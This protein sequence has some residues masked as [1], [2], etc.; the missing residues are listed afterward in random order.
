MTATNSI[1]PPLTG[2]AR[3]W[4][5]R[6]PVACCLAVMA[7]AIITAPMD[8]YFERRFQ[9]GNLLEVLR[10]TAMLLVALLTV[11]E[12]PKTLT[13]GFSLV[14]PALVFRWACHLWPELIPDWIHLVP[15]VLFMLFVVGHLLRFVLCAARV[16]AEVLCASVVTYLLLGW[17]W[18]VGYV[19]ASEMLP[20]AFASTVGPPAYHH[21]IGFEALYFSFITITTV[22]Y[23]DIVPVSAVARMLAM[24][25]AM[26]GTLYMTVLVARLVSLYA[27]PAPSGRDAAAA[28]PEP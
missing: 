27:A 9:L 6:Y 28:A 8:E 15:T 12:R 13:L 4:F 21:L 18:A 7:L 26:T 22:G 14:L 20:G 19:V 10:L 11:G 23:G 16:N 5:R 17:L 2:S 24:T 3:L 1:P 25:E